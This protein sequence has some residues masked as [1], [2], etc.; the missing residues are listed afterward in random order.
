MTQNL[1]IRGLTLWKQDEKTFQ[2]HNSI[3]SYSISTHR[4]YRG[5]VL[6]ISV[7]V[8]KVRPLLES[9]H[10]S[11][12]HTNSNETGLKQQLHRPHTFL[13]YFQ[14]GRHIC[15]PTV[16]YRLLERTFLH[17]WSKRP[18]AWGIVEGLTTQ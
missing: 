15:R 11:V 16:N 2:N 14:S 4:D 9:S 10:P 7:R 1:P 6:P 8:T 13:L 3:A 18:N 5:E 17:T 12:L